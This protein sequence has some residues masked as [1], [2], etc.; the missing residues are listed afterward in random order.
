[1][2]RCSLGSCARRGP[3]PCR[4]GADLAEEVDVEA[5]TAHALRLDLRVL[6]VARDVDA[7][8][9]PI[10]EIG[11]RRPRLE[12]RIARN[13]RG[14]VAARAS[15]LVESA[16]PR[17]KSSSVGSSIGGMISGTSSCERYATIVVSI[18]SSISVA[19]PSLSMSVGAPS[20]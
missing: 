4:G 7:D 14:P 8:R 3:A 9:R 10:R 1:M 2:R 20:P 18:P 15:D 6:A 12:D 13:E 16:R 11:M 17:A 5:R 19:T